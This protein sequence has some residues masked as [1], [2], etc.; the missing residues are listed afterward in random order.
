MSG[1]PIG[2]DLREMHT[3]LVIAHGQWGRLEPRKYARVFL[4]FYNTPPTMS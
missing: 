4:H 3:Y 1:L 2:P